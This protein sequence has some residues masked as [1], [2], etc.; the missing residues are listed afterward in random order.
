MKCRT[1]AAPETNRMVAK[2]M[3]TTEEPLQP[4]SKHWHTVSVRSKVSCLAHG[5]ADLIQPHDLTI[6]CSS[7]I[8]AEGEKLIDANPQVATADLILTGEF[9]PSAERLISTVLDDSEGKCAVLQVAL[10]RDRRLKGDCV[11]VLIER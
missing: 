11:T 4:S 9:D 6:R 2:L 5:F 3:L 7:V 1:R 10:D 8:A